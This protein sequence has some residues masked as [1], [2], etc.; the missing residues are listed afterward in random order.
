MI[1][2][3]VLALLGLASPATPSHTRDASSWDGP[4]NPFPAHGFCHPHA[5]KHGYCRAKEQHI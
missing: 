3:L 1:V 2:L 4:S 5:T